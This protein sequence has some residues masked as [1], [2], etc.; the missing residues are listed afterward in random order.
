[1]AVQAMKID[2]YHVDAFEVANFEPIC[3]Q[4]RAQGVDANLV[5]VP[6]GKNTA[7]AG[8]FDFERFNAFCTA[9]GIPYVTE[10]RPDAALGVTTQNAQ[11]LRDYS[12]RVRLMYGPIVYPMAWGLQEISVK[13]F[14]A[15]LV[16]GQSYVECFS[17]WL[18]R[19]RLR[20]VGYPRC[21]EYFAGRLLR[22]AIRERWGVN[23]KTPVL[24][25]L[26]TW[27]R[28]TGFDTF[29]PALIKLADQYQ[30]VLRPHH[31][32]VRMEPQRMDLMRES[33]L[34]I[35]DDA[36]DLLEVYAG[37]DVVLS[38]VRSG[39][40]FEACAC[41]VPAVGLVL[42]AAEI[43]GWLA[44]NR[45]DRMVPLCHDPAT[46]EQA[47]ED[48]MAPAYAAER[49]AWADR[50]V[51][52]R[53]GSAA[54][55]A[56][57]ALIA[58]AS[59]SNPRIESAEIYRCK[60]TIVLPTYNHLGYLPQAIDG[61]LKQKLEDFEL[62]IVNDGSTDGT[63][64]YLATLNDP[65]VKVIH[66]SNGGLP[67]ALNRGFA[68][69]SGEFWTWT[70]ADNVT[71]PAWLEQLVAGFDDAPSSV[72]LVYSGFGLVDMDGRFL[73]IRRGQKMQL[74]SLMAK[75]PGMASFL[76]RA[77]V[78][79]QV[80]EYDVTLNGAEDWD[81]WLRMLEVC[82]AKYV[83]GIQYYYRVHPNSMTSNMPDKISNASVG[84]ILK[85][86]HRQGN[87][88]DLNRIYPRLK[89]AESQA[90]AQWQARARLG[91]ILSQSPFCPANFVVEPLVQAL[92]L[93]YNLDLHKNLIIYLLRI[94]RPELAKFSIEEFLAKNAS[95]ELKDICDLIEKNSFELLNKLETKYVLDSDLVFD[96]GHGDVL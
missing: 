78:A 3:R 57:D 51:A 17:G 22:A 23:D 32:T 36:F 44:A 26:P 2:F 19:D 28:N 11:V 31:C 88:F 21:D 76:Y 4:L 7:A 15:V 86:R 72:G 37:A 92:S 59:P 75:N 5:A 35:L 68:E 50:H 53:D 54:R 46:L 8:W 66:Q 77:S 79:R 89:F 70:S 93:H 14:D 49:D 61:I 6:G 41:D 74:D 47:L 63:E 95:V 52:Y 27:E 38:D 85:L 55:Q 42:D 9:R 29:F 58:L 18:S 87:A 30:I 1:M 91:T 96:I 12:F 67:A 24:A 82:D 16:H 20:I 39:S 69:A 60:V 48:A 73:S 65:R 13:P 83:D 84:T 80:G 90:L 34:I 40:L 25:F 56:A 45:V 62:I 71:G 10:S 43:T 94:G 64:A 81:M 33:G